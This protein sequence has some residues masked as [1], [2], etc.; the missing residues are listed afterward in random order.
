ML[1]VEEIGVIVSKLKDDSFRHLY[2]EKSRE[3]K[4]DIR[5]TFS[6]EYPPFLDIDRPKESKKNKDY[7]RKIFQNPAMAHRSRII[8]KV[9]K[10]EQSE[11]FLI[12]YPTTETG[13]NPLRDYCENNF[14]GFNTLTNWMFS[15]GI[16][17]YGDDPNSVVATLDKN[18]PERESEGYKPYP[19]IFGSDDVI[20]FE[21]G[22]YCVVREKDEEND[23]NTRYY[24]IDD[25]NY[26]ILEPNVWRTNTE[27]I[28]V[29][30][31]CGEMPAFKIGKYIQEESPKGEI[32]HKSLLTDSLP[33]FR[34]AI[35]RYND[36]EVELIHHINTLEWKI[37]PRKCGNCKGKGEIIETGGKKSCPTCQGKGDMGWNQ[38]DILEIEM[39]DEKYLE[40]KKTFPFNQPGGYV[41]RNIDALKVIIESINN[42]ID[43]AYN[44][45]DFGILRKRGIIM[46][47]SGEAKQYDRLEFSQKIY[48]E[49]RHIIENIMLPIYRYIDRQLFGHNPQ[50]SETRVPEIV[51]PINFDIMSPEMILDEI[52]IANEAGMSKE[53]VGALELK[54]CKLVNGD[55]SREAITLSDEI[56][57]NPHYGKTVEE[58]VLLYG[59]GEG[60]GFNGIKETDFIIAC[61]FKGFID[62]AMREFKDWVHKDEKDKFAVLEGYA[63]EVSEAKSASKLAAV[64]KEMKLED[65]A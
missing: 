34:S 20:W 13:E 31:N 39:Q 59:G 57:L 1:S 28:A 54:Y 62:R 23:I 24:L 3:V 42:H 16:Y 65:A 40:G 19:Y 5:D 43:D 8:D 7:R 35:R 37:A 45:I 55:K 56:N 15:L 17:K 46:A 51:I 41:P 12:N 30:H 58:L 48:S 11:D 29:P 61:N 22:R 36:Q 49:G 53:V 14:N 52:K 50:S 25:T 60:S 63:K 27:L 64:D 26:Y 10:V 32:L 21:K 4:R 44:A 33:F 9:T 2:Y 38:L 18:P 6:K 47:E